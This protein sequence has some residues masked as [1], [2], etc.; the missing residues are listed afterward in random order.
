MPP[1][2]ATDLLSLPSRWSHNS[3]PPP[4]CKAPHSPINFRL[5]SLR[6]I[7]KAIVGSDLGMTPNNDGEV[8]RLTLPQLTSERRNEFLKVVA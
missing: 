8:I 3:Q 7:E 2:L 4:T 5:F 6:A 1:P